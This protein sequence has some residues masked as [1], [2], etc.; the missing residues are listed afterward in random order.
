MNKEIIVF[1]VDGIILDFNKMF[2]L[3]ILQ[4]YNTVLP[5]NPNTWDFDWCGD[6]NTL[7]QYINEFVNSNI[8]LPLLDDSI[9]DFLDFLKHKYKIIFVTA[10]NNESLRIKNLRLLKIYYD[11]I[12]FVRQNEKVTV[13]NSLKPIAIFEDCPNHILNIN[14]TN[15]NAQIFVPLHWNYDKDLNGRIIKYNKF[16]DLYVYFSKKL[17]I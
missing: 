1:D 12:I 13:I 17:N 14:N 11:E 3:Y 4:K 5:Y 9:L 8:M 15:D 16:R 10:Y 6:K 7:I 2:I